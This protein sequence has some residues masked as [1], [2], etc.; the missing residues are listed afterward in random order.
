MTTG[1]Y[2]YTRN[3]MVF[4]MLSIYLSIVLF[5]NSLIDLVM[6][7]GV[8]VIA[9]SFL[10]TSEEKRLRND[11]GEQFV[12]YKIRTSMIV[13]MPSKRFRKD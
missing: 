1:P 2:R 3:P 6:V 10:K 13:P 8:T 9:V 12:Q 5:L 11:F 4:G 7:L